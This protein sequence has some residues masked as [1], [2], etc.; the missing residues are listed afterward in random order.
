MGKSK[1]H[2]E[3]RREQIL[4]LGS[5]NGEESEIL[6][7]LKKGEDQIELLQ[8]PYRRFDIEEKSI[9]YK[10]VYVWYPPGITAGGRLSDRIY[11]HD[12][13]RNAMA[14]V[15]VIDS[16]D[17]QEVERAEF[18]LAAYRRHR[19]LKDVLIIAIATKQDNPDAKSPK[20]L[21]E[22]INERH[23]VSPIKVFPVVVDTGEGINE[24]FDWLVA[25]V[26][27]QYDVTGPWK[28]LAQDVSQDGKAGFNVVKGAWKKVVS[29]LFL[30][31][32][33]TK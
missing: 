26:A 4:L 25:K 5:Q 3:P 27:G 29:K 11:L 7:W 24:C 18:E 32:S 16:S 31:G 30:V 19:N 17:S 2:P 9:S 22:I 12:F 20:Q 28:E 1:K 21:E 6:D 15:Y 33:K 10:G 13:F 14:V 23:Q 8:S